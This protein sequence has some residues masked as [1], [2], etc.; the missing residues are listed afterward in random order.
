MVRVTV[1]SGAAKSV[2]PRSKRGVLRRKMGKKPKLAAANRTQIEVYGEA[3]LEFEKGGRQCGMRFLVSDVKKPLASVSSM[4]DEGN[5]I[6][7]NRKWGNYIENDITGEKIP[8]ERVGETFE[9]VPKTKKLEER[10][11]SYGQK[12]DEIS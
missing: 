5:T 4:N 6:V 1:D 10:R 8:M 2:W 12:M 9:M 7:I 11:R 3:V